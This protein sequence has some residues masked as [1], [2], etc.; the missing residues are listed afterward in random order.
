VGPCFTLCTKTS[1]VN[2]RE[3]EIRLYNK[4]DAAEC[5]VMSAFPNLFL[6]RPVA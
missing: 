2:I 1:K 4:E 5:L 6:S 3:L